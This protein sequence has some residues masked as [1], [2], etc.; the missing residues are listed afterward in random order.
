M[1]TS[2]RLISSNFQFW[3][4][5]S[6]GA[7]P[8]DLAA[9]CPNYH[10][11]D[12]VG[13]VSLHLED[14]VLQTSY[15]LL[16]LTTAFYDRL[17]ARSTD[18]FDYP[19]HFAFVGAEGTSVLVGEGL[20][21]LNT[22]KLWDAWSWLDVWPDAKW[23]PAS[24]T[25]SGMLQRVFEY[26]INR[27]FWPRTLRLGLNEAPLP[28]YVWQM[29]KTSLKSV[30]LYG[31]DE[32]ATVGERVEIRVMPEIDEVVQESLDRLPAL[33]DVTAAQ[34]S[35]R[36]QPYER[37]GIDEFLKAMQVPPNLSCAHGQIAPG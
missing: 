6:S 9:F 3:Q 8:V 21:P 10:E 14:G 23:V 5:T 33:V 34:R 24:A 7:Q 37:V 30:Y 4:Q 22:E 28:S 36:V 25:A 27:I 16:A 13:V 19:Q 20:L 11:Q 2:K 18:F 1:H 15:A 29:L 26:Q 17:R 12:R 31:E 35:R 32:I